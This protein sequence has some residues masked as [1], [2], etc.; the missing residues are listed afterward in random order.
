[1][2]KFV[3]N[4]WGLNRWTKKYPRWA[5]NYAGVL[6][7]VTDAQMLSLGLSGLEGCLRQC[8]RGEQHGSWRSVFVAI[9]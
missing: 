5:G 1:M 3:R 7:F 9:S 2:N 4:C 6:Q 8:N